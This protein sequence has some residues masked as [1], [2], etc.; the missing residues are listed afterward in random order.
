MNSKIKI[1]FAS[2]CVAFA[3]CASQTP[4][5]LAAD[6][7]YGAGYAAANDN[8][9]HNAALLPT[10][11]DVA[12]KLPKLTTGGLSDADLGS[13]NTEIGVLAQ[14]TTVLKGLIPADTSKLDLALSFF[15][16]ASQAVNST[17]AGKA[18]TLDQVAATTVLIQFA[19][20]L[21]GGIG[22]WQGKSSAIVPAKA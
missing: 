3:G 11:Q 2:L 19:N 18:P 21:S 4:Q 22:Y 20:G 13:L 7:V 15:A 12:A 14:N 9:N 5:Q 6:A 10:I 1:L 17:L 8:L 16:G